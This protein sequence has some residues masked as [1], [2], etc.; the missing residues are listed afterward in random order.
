MGDILVAQDVK[1][2]NL[3][4][5]VA[6]MK[7]LGVIACPIELKDALKTKCDMLENRVVLYEGALWYVD[8]DRELLP[9]QFDYVEGSMTILNRADLTIGIGVAPQTILERVDRIHN[10]GDIICQPE[11]VPAIEA[12]L[13]L[14]DGEVVQQK[15][16]T[17]D[18]DAPTIGNANYLVL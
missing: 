4:S 2:D 8:N 18:E 11:H 5:A 10:L 9:E 16:N 12:R 17:E 3:N 7:S 1:A 15:P 13:G 14:R 6:A